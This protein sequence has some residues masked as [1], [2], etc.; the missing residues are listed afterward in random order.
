MSTK[1]PAL[2]DVL[3]PAIVAPPATPPVTSVQL[4]GLVVMQIVR[5]AKQAS[6]QQV[7][8]QLLGLETAGRME[9]TYAFPFPGK[10]L[11]EDGDDEPFDGEH[12]AAS[13]EYIGRDLRFCWS[14]LAPAREEKRATVCRCERAGI[15]FRSVT[16]RSAAITPVFC[17][18]ATCAR[19]GRG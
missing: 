3:A 18:F 2:K 7:T 5:H 13:A 16:V 12:G 19:S 8:G 4:D 10:V 6:P 14:R 17:T 15:L 11:N 1:T 9:V